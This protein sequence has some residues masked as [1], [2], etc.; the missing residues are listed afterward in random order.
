LFYGFYLHRLGFVG[1]AICGE[2]HLAR[3]AEKQLARLAEKQ[4]ARLA[5]KQL[6]RLVEENDRVCCMLGLVVSR[7]ENRV[8]LDYVVYK[9]E[10]ILGCMWFLV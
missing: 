7:S 6:A 2:K 5:E 3:L 4:L 8:W 10:K 1:L 9:G